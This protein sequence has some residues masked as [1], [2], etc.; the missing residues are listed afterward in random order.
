MKISGSYSLP[1][2]QERAYQVLLDPAILAR[3]MPG[4]DRLEKIGEDLYAMRMKM[5]IASISGLFD[6]TVRLAEQ[7][8]NTSYKLIVEGAGK[9]G[10]VKGEGL[11]SLSPNEQ[12]T[13]V[14]YDGDVHIGGTIAS[15]GQ[16]LIDTT[17]KMLIKRFF[18]K[19]IAEV[20]VPD[21]STRTAGSG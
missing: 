17:S 14:N 4:C 3:C 21:E 8:P 12:G 9:I 15:V 2:A 5:L 10:F 16:R 20:A 18:T 11:L 19:L 7:N 6:G 1:V 13:H